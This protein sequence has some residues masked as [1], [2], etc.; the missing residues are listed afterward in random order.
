MKRILYIGSKDTGVRC[1]QWMIERARKRDFEIV[2]V[3]ATPDDD[4]EHWWGSVSR[5]AREAGLE[6]HMPEDIN[7]EAFVE[8]M[9]ALDLDLAYCV[10]HPQIFKRVLGIAKEGIINLH[11]APLPLY[12]GCLPIPH[13]IIDGR[14]EHGVTLHFITEGIDSGPIVGQRIVPIYEHDTG[15]DLYRR[16]EDAGVELFKEVFE[17]ALRGELEPVAQDESRAIYHY[18]RELDN[19]RVDLSWDPKRI[20]DFVRALDFPPYPRPYIDCGEGRKIYLTTI[21]YET[22][23]DR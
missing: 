16:C 20:Y 2:G 9:L 18:R 13:A 1:L 4:E 19:R 11:F 5:T 17:K 8:R 12:R 23:V 7:D 22:E 14:T 3:V 10:F 6:V 21:P 15:R